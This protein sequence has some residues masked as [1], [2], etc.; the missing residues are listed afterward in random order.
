MARSPLISLVVP[1]FNEAGCLARLHDEFARVSARMPDVD[2]E[3]V[4]VDDGSDDETLAVIKGLHD[5]DERVRYV[6]FSRHFGKEA[7]LLAGL[8]HARGDFVAPLDADLQDPPDLL[9]PMYEAVEKEG[10]DCVAAR[11]RD[12]DGEGAVR[13]ALSKGFYRLFNRVCEV[14]VVEGARDFRL[15]SRRMVDSVLEMGE[16]N[17]FSKGIFDWVG[18]PTTWI[19]YDRVAPSREGSRWSLRG[20]LKYSLDGIFNFSSAPLS[21]AMAL[22]FVLGGAGLVWASAITLRAVAVGITPPAWEVLA[23]IVLAAASVQLIC[24]GILGQYLARAYVETKRRPSYFVS[25]T[26][27]GTAEPGHVRAEHQGSPVPEPAAAATPD[28]AVE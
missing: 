11:R 25:E 17:R 8:R 13:S 9:Q 2:F 15:M 27:E 1:A 21:I 24:T 12:R 6:S 7:G 19:E 14:S 18:Y 22:G 26:E 16:H 4:F 10:W 23:C 5:V 3:Y 28:G 20:L